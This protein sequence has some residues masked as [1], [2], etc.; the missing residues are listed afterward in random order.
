MLCFYQAAYQI[1]IMQYSVPSW[2]FQRA[3][4]SEVHEMLVAYTYQLPQGES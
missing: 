4:V 2:F 3:T 1:N